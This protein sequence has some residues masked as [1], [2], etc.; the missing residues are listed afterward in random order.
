MGDKDDSLALLAQDAENLE[1]VI[2][3]SRGQNAGRLVEDQDFR[4]TIHG[5][6]DFDTLLQANGQFLDHRI[7][8][9]FQ[10]VIVL[11]A[12]QLL[13][14]GCPTL[15]KRCSAFR[16]Q[17]DVFKHGEIFHQHEMLM[18]H[19]NTGIDRGLA[20]AN[21]DRRAIHPDFTG[22][23]LVK[24]VEDRHQ[25][26]FSGTIFPD[27]AVDRTLGNGQVDI[28]IGVNG[29]EFFIDAHEFDCW[30]HTQTETSPKAGYEKGA[31]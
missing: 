21:Y 28:L 16:A 9:D 8:I 19:A 6:E 15:G 10:P 25:G 4:A 1:K 2:G 29:T 17:H 24:T 20:V 3:L 13:A 11:E 12:L 31:R 7:G 18:H 26:R 23:G 14:R 30:V 27:D 5:F 22:I